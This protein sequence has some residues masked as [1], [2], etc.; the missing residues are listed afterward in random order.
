VKGI[1]F[2]STPHR[3]SGSVT[4][5]NLL[6]N[7]LNAILTIAPSSTGS[8]RNDLTELLRSNSDELQALATNFRN[9]A[10]GIK[11]VSCYEMNITPPL[12]DLVIIACPEANISISNL[13]YRLLIIT[14]EHWPSPAR[15][16]YLWRAVTTT[17]FAVF[18]RTTILIT[19]MS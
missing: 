17:K 16:L 9:Q 18:Q 1:V 5:P 15:C 14:P 6:G 2:L 12:K 8:F 3:G 13:G 7:V 19:K 11:I 10:I 4:W